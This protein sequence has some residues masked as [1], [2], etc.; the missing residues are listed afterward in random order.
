MKRNQMAYVR[1]IGVIVFVVLLAALAGTARGQ[2]AGQGQLR[3]AYVLPTHQAV[4]YLYEA[5]PGAMMRLVTCEV[6]RSGSWF[7]PKPWELVVLN[8]NPLNK[9][10][11]PTIY[12]VTISISG[13]LYLLASPAT[14]T[15]GRVLVSLDDGVTWQTMAGPECRNTIIFPILK[16]G[17]P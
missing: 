8:A 17:A 6:E 12:R 3:L 16:R 14:L 4:L 1:T 9:Y 13:N 11:S 7:G 5:P 10:V 2:G 15:P